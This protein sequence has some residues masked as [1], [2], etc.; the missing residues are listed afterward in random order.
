VGASRTSHLAYNCSDSASSV[1]RSGFI[2]LSGRDECRSASGLFGGRYIDSCFTMSTYGSTV[3][4][5]VRV[6]APCRY[7]ALIRPRCRLSPCWWLAQGGDLHK[8]TQLS[9]FRLKSFLSTSAVYVVRS[10]CPHYLSHLGDWRGFISDRTT[11]R[12]RRHGEGRTA[13]P[14]ARCHRNTLSCDNVFRR[15]ICTTCGNAT[16]CGAIYR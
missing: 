13:R 10:R 1:L 16:P 12:R 6:L 14:L 2:F 11:G 15:G 9:L 7:C 8:E 5:P 3:V 4:K